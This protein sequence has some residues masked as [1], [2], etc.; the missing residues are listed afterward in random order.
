MRPVESEDR[1]SFRED[2]HIHVV[3]KDFDDREAI[4]K[5]HWNIREL[6]CTSNKGLWIDYT[7]IYEHYLGWG[8]NRP[9]YNCPPTG[10]DIVHRTERSMWGVTQNR[11]RNI[12]KLLGDQGKAFSTH[13]NMP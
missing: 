9:L 10:G 11:Q 4:D 8:Q 1:R 5:I 3:T 6:D 12:V 7:P 2:Y 13:I